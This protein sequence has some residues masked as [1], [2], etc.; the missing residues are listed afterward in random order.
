[1][2]GLVTGG[3]AVGY[4]LVQERER[5]AGAVANVQD[6]LTNDGL[7][8]M[9]KLSEMADAFLAKVHDTFVAAA[10]PTN[11][12]A[13][14]RHGLTGQSEDAAT[15]PVARERPR[16]PKTRLRENDTNTGDENADDPAYQPE[17]SH[18]RRRTHHSGPDQVV[19]PSQHCSSRAAGATARSVWQASLRA[20]EAGGDVPM[21]VEQESNDTV[22]SAQPTAVVTTEVVIYDHAA[23]HYDRFA[24][25]MQAGLTER[26]DCDDAITACLEHI[27]NAE[28]VAMLRDAPLVESIAQVA[29][30]GR[31]QLEQ[32]ESPVPV[33]AVVPAATAALTSAQPSHKRKQRAAAVRATAAL[34]TDPDY[35]EPNKHPIK[36]AKPSAPPAKEL[37]LVA[38]LADTGLSPLP[39]PPDLDDTLEGVL[40][41]SIAYKW[42][43]P[44]GWAVGR[45]APPE[46][47]ESNCTV[48]YKDHCSEQQ[49]LRAAAYGGEAYG[50]WVLVDGTLAPPIDAFEKGK[51]SVAGVWKRAQQLYFHLPDELKV[52]REAAS[53]AKAVASQAAAEEEMNTGN[54]T[55]GARVYARGL[56]PDGER[57]WFVCKL[58]LTRA[59][60]P[61]LQVEFLATLDGETSAL[62]LP[63]P[64][65]AFVP[66]VD[67]SLDE[68]RR[69]GRLIRAV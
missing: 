55:I 47:K 9:Q 63:L 54:F 44:W 59:R 52:A 28:M 26:L 50:A 58:L 31:S 40:G 11:L 25:V 17:A 20:E 18:R 27:N 62:Q 42:E 46:D 64:R 36:V 61:P 51:Y 43:P 60:Y 21:T 33:Q 22:A 7:T 24:R 56:A 35:E 67:V 66:A 14:V 23:W 49:T 4:A 65:K 1:M 41:R 34:D 16:A 53:E 48:L 6:T 3:L 15:T 38:A 12:E 69:A 13:A 29:V 57:A 39:I 45:L 8:L 32:R 2:A 19:T 30:E 5:V 10:P 68:P 37:S